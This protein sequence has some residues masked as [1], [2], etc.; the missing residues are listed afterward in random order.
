MSVV[1][2]GRIGSPADVNS[3]PGVM[4]HNVA[5]YSIDPM[6]DSWPAVLTVTHRGFYSVI[7]ATY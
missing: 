7:T 5:T 4:L 6:S 1:R 2:C 3:N